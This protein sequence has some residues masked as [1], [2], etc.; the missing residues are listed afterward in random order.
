MDK[1]T[2]RLVNVA[3]M[4]YEQDRTQS[5]IADRYGIS[6][7]MVS[8]LLKEARDRGIVT[9]R[10]NAPKGESGG[11]P[12]LMELVGRCFGIYDGVAVPGGPND[13][14]TNEAVA[15]AAISYLSGLGG[16]GL[17]IGWGHIIGDVVK[18]MEQKAKLV[19]IGTFVCPLIGNGGVGLKNYHSNELVRVIAEH[20]GAEPAFLYSP[21]Y[22]LSEQELNLTKELDNYRM[23]SEAWRKLDV[24]L[25]NIGNFPS[26]PDFASEARYGD[27]LVKQKAVGRILNY[28][29]N[30]EGRILYSETDYAIQIPLEL[31]R[32]TKHVVG[33][34]SAN[35][36]SAALRAVLRTGLVNYLIAPG[37]VVETALK[38]E[39]I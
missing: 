25:V 11:A 17:G 22:V 27:V 32:K 31:L 30:R 2:E 39:M 18:H 37:R 20:S 12:S 28:F 19:P 26:V 14:T 21:A 34:C 16:T 6:R 13:Q 7:P 36:S 24:A 23:V 1:K 35:T 15:E 4:Y 3:R 9:I 38:E 8:K 33:I 5:E 10:I 29:V